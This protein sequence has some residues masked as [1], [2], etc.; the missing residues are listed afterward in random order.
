MKSL[1][2]VPV[3][4]GV[5]ASTCAAGG[6]RTDRYYSPPVEQ[7][8]YSGVA[9]PPLPRQHRNH[10]GFYYGHFICADHC[11][12]DYKVYSCSKASTGC[13]HVGHGYCDGAGHLRCGPGLF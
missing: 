9:M 7:F 12:L 5:M 4:L 13:C 10:C 1:I 3:L 8:T 2:C 11:G 6:W